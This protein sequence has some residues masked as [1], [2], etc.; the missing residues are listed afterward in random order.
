MMSLNSR[1]APALDLPARFMGLSI[2]SLA[3]AVFSAPWTLPL[4]QGQFNGFRLLALVHLMTLGFIGS[5]IIGASY[6]L[7]P[8]ALQVPLSSVTLG[9]MSFPFYLGGLVLFLTGLLREW[10]PGLAIGGFLLGI[11]FV[12][13]IVV[14]ARTF[15]RSSHKDAVAW[16]IAL[17]SVLS[18][19][20]MVLGVM[21]AFN[22]G[23]GFLAGRLLDVLAAHIIVM[24]VGW[25]TITY[26]GVAYRLVGMFTLAENH[27]SERQAWIALGLFG[28][29]TILLA[30]RFM[31]GLPAMVGWFGAT[32]ILGGGVLF[33]LQLR[34]MYR[35]RMRRTFD[36]HMPFAIA[37]AAMLLLAA[38]SLFAGLVLGTSP[39]N[40]LWVATGWLVIFG[41]V[42][43]AIQ[44][45]F[46]KISTFLVWLKRYA[47]VAG[48]QPV[49]KLEEMYSRTLGMTG[50][51]LW[52]AAIAGGWLAL[53]LEHPW[54]PLVGLLLVAGALCF[55]FNVV[56]IAR[57]WMP[58]MRSL[59]A[60][61]IHPG[62]G[63]RA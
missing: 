46:Y 16:H 26:T 9:R 14:I 11:A 25:V 48:T 51:W 29:G 24:L 53:V 47:P 42:S 30:L 55:V 10:L 4:M 62:T 41:M 37:S 33:S 49:P 15:L 31:P 59:L 56:N 7:V 45:F 50:F 2:A 44:G 27:V 36:I 1:N 38:G 32:M 61:A 8:V 22:K 23:N 21:L 57:H 52:T 58:S 63:V 12:L 17:A 34:R 39:A 43:T 35:K 28:G 18:G 40:P 3:L 60:V 19:T 54:L 5:M 20:G 6:Q 13:Y